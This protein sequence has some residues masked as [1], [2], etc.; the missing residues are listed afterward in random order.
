M[1]A[2]RWYV[3]LGRQ[4]DRLLPLL[5]PALIPRPGPTACSQ[6]AA[7]SSQRDGLELECGG[8]SAA[9]EAAAAAQADA[10]GLQAAL[11]AEQHMV[12]Q[13]MGLREEVRA[14]FSFL[15]LLSC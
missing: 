14:V 15:K 5:P 4:R 8:M 3:A 12:M 11:G 13:L 7:L 1:L 10:Q 2:C 9:H 6:V